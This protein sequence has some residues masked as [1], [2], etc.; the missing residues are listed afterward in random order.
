MLKQ[1]ANMNNN[2]P[3]GAL[4]G[5]SGKVMLTRL[6]DTLLQAAHTHVG[7]K[8]VG[9]IGQCWLTKEIIVREKN[10]TIAPAS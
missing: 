10:R 8:A 5:V 2:R 1:E 7:M 6:K 9:M 4:N 3:E